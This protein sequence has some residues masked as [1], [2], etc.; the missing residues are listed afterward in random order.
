MNSEI[1]QSKARKLLSAYP[2]QDWAALLTDLVEI[3]VVLRKN[4]VPHNLVHRYFGTRIQNLDTLQKDSVGLDETPFGQSLKVF[5]ALFKIDYPEQHTYDTLVTMVGFS[6]E[7]VMHTLLTLCPQKVILVF[8]PESKKFDGEIN[9]AEYINFLLNLYDSQYLPELQVIVLDNTD[10]AHV[11][12]RVYE[13]IK[14]LSA[15][16]KVAVDVTGG[17][18]SMDASAFLAASLRNDVSIFYVDYE[19]YNI[20]YGYPVWGTEFLNKLVNPYA[21]F[22]VREEHLIKD[23]WGKGNFAA[24]KDLAASLTDNALTEC[25]A[26][27]YGLVEKRDY[28]VEIKKASSCYDAWSRFDYKT[29]RSYEFKNFNEH[30]KGALSQLCRCAEVFE[31]NNAELALELSVDRYMR[32]KSATEYCDWNK[33]ALCYAQS[34]E[35]LLRFCC[36]KDWSTLKHNRKRFEEGMML[37]E[38]KTILFDDNDYFSDTLLGQRLYDNINDVRNKLSH[39][40][41]FPVQDESGYKQVMATMRSVADELLIAFVKRFDIDE[42]KITEYKEYLAF[43]SISDNFELFKPVVSLL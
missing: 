33:S 38:L 26:K 16:G 13:K 9:A 43:C 17:K 7:P 12:A 40:Q 32:G 11:F 4:S 23:L 30:H 37:G 31:K 2:G 29:A 15:K 3:Q 36:M 5:K 39:F 21:F 1:A 22:S 6:L 24:V 8:T 10:T 19:A 18:K 20:S 42:R 27:T 35:V 14:E 41:C 34:V 28:F 25:M